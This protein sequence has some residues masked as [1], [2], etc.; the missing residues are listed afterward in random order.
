MELVELL[1]AIDDMVLRI[2]QKTFQIF[3]GMM[4]NCL[5]VI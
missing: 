1:Y 2:L 4:K 3:Q 5:K